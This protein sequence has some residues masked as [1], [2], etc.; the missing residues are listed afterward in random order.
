MKH[1]FEENLDDFYEYLLLGPLST[2]YTAKKKTSATEL[3]EYSNLIIDKFAIHSAS[4]FH[5]S[6]GIIELR[7][8]GEKV[9][10]TG[11]DLFTVNSTFRAMMEN[12]ATF[13]NIF[14]ESKTTEE[15]WFR[16]LLW[17][18]D[19][20]FEKQKFDIAESDFEGAKEIL[21]KDKLILENTIQ[22]FESLP[23]YQSLDPRQLYKIYKVDKSGKE[24]FNWRFTIDENGSITPL[25]ISD[26]IKHTCRIKAFTNNY[27]YTSIHTHTNY[28]AIEHFQQMRGIPISDK[29][30]K[31]IT[32]LAIYLTCL[33]IRDMCILDE[34]AKSEFQ[35][36]PYMVR[37]Y[38][39]GMANTIKKT[40]SI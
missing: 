4:F 38:I 22:E 2:L 12:Y 13:N 33:F 11:Y 32:K 24:K 7:N 39:D 36:L 25:K 17:K 6:K 21:E 27:R 28:L 16:F 26:L 1:L 3:I 35:T 34:N 20:L 15:Q 14:I 30:T 18:I 10:M 5:L 29:Y 40:Y 23:F 9:K 37:D 8:S 31:P 19:G